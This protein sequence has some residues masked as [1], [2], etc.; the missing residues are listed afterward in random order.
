MLTRHQQVTRQGVIEHWC[1]FILVLLL[2]RHVC[3]YTLC[4]IIISR[5]INHHAASKYCISAVMR[6]IKAAFQVIADSL[7][8]QHK[9]KRN[10]LAVLCTEIK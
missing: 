3:R 4:I 8:G 6:Q 2:A 10:I 1:M 7:P 5:A 9:I